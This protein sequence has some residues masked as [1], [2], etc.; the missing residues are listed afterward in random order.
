VPPVTSGARFLSWMS[1]GACRQADPELFFPA[2]AVAGPAAR[3]AEA[4]RAVCG[5][6]AVRANCLSYALEAMPAGIWGG[7]TE[8]ERRAARGSSVRRARL[9]AGQQVPPGRTA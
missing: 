1:H 7:T 9:A 4:A 8:E 5:P 3:Q 6:C 2:E